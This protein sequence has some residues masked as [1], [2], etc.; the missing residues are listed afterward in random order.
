MTLCRP[1]TAQRPQAQYS[2]RFIDMGPVFCC[3]GPDW[4]YVKHFE[5]G[6]PLPKICSSNHDSAICC[7]SLR[8]CFLQNFIAIS[9]KWIDLVVLFLFSVKSKLLPA[10]SGSFQPFLTLFFGQSDLFRAF[11][12]TMLQ[13]LI[14]F[15]RIF[16][17]PCISRLFPSF[18]RLCRAILRLF[19]GVAGLF[20]AH[21]IFAMHIFFLPRASGL[22]QSVA[23]IYLTTFFIFLVL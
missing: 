15:M 19:W 4:A 2:I 7:P 12:G 5:M 21:I 17:L 11:R 9:Q 22:F 20:H 23:R 14:Y 13:L 6:I 8:P 1:R 18:A 10:V 3:C 16:F